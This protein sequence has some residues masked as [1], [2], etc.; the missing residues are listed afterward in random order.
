MKS[1]DASVDPGHWFGRYL[2]YL[3]D[4]ISIS[5]S[6]YYNK[7]QLKEGLKAETLCAVLFLSYNKNLW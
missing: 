1:I 7:E 6:F 2:Y 5:Q 3:F 4:W